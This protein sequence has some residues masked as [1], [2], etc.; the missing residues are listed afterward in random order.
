MATVKEE[1]SKIQTNGKRPI[2][3]QSLANDP[4]NPAPY[5]QAPKF[6]SVHAASEYLWE[7]FIEPA[8]YT[9]LMETVGS[10]VPIMDIVQI[11]LFTDFERGLWNPDL[12]MMLFEPATY[13]IMALAERQDLD[14]VIYNGEDDDEMD[15]ELALGSFLTEEK[16]KRLKKSKESGIV[17]AGILTS[18]ME[19]TLETLPEIETDAPV[20]PSLMGAPQEEEEEQPTGLLARPTGV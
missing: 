20:Q 3:G 14:M 8:T 10:G 13:M 17:P 2:P 6:T 15:D 12:M 5:E 9:S 1:Y 11:I 18:E 4:E 7:S 19:S 16:L